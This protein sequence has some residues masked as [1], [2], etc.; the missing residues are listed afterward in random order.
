MFA[1]VGKLSVKCHCFF[2][3]NRKTLAQWFHF[4][5]LQFYKHVNSKVVIRHCLIQLGSP[6]S[7]E[8]QRF[9]DFVLHSGSLCFV[10][11]FFLHHFNRLHVEGFKTSLPLSW[12]LWVLSVLFKVTHACHKTKKTSSLNMLT[13]HKFARFACCQQKRLH[14]G[15]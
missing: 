2:L 11:F 13:L 14:W 9:A 5:C 6:P 15:L 12:L 1:C 3:I 8:H 10:L 7:S 4:L